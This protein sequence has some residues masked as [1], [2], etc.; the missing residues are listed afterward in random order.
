MRAFADD[1]LEGVRQKILDA[2]FAGATLVGHS[3]GGRMSSVLAADPT[4]AI[5]RL[6]LLDSGTPTLPAPPPPG[7]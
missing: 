6:V 5:R 2:G 4:L 3:M 7:G 1:V